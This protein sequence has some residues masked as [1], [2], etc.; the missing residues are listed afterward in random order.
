MVR[1]V[2]EAMRKQELKESLPVIR[3][4]IDYE[5][6][7]LYDA[8]QTWDTVTGK[9]VGCVARVDGG[10]ATQLARRAAD[11]A[12]EAQRDWASA[13]PRSRAKIL[14]DAVD[15]LKDR[16][17]EIALTLALEAGKRLPEAAGKVAGSAEYLTWFAEEVRRPRGEHYT[18]EDPARRQLSMHRPL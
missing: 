15:L 7:T 12:A 17:D 10:E 1:Y 13:S 9:S 16:A 5:L 14:H 8:M 3:M 11:R 2:M 6:A 4:E 18:S